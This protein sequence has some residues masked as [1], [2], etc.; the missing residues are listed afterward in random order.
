MT[1]EDLADLLGE[2]LLWEAVGAFVEQPAQLIEMIEGLSYLDRETVDAVNW[3][4]V[5]DSEE[6]AVTSVVAAGARL[7]IGFE[8]PFVLTAW[9]RPEGSQKGVCLLRVISTIVGECL[10]PGVAAYDWDAED[11]EGMDAQNLLAHA[12]LVEVSEYEYRDTE[13]GSC[14]RKDESGAWVEL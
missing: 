9:C 5:Q 3:C 11:W 2:T 6:F 7:R 14:A 13:A 1:C 10:I 4:E 8:M 12:P